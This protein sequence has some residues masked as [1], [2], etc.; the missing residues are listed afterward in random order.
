MAGGNTVANITGRVQKN[1]AAL[2]QA[3]E[4][5]RAALLV[6]P[7]GTYGIGTVAVAALPRTMTRALADNAAESRARAGGLAARFPARSSVIAATDR[8]VLVIPSNGVGMKEIGAEYALGEVAVTAND[9]KLLGRRLQLTFAD[10]S[11]VVVDAQRGQP[12]EEFA[13][14]LG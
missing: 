2:L 3:G 12:F 4:T 8:R 6:E 13:S 5:V 14:A 10:G 1:A 9:G 7:K 11:Q